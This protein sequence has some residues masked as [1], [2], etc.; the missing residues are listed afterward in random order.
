MTIAWLTSLSILA[1]LGLLGFLMAAAILPGHKWTHYLPVSYLLGSGVFTWALFLLAWAGM[2]INV[3][4]VVWLFALMLLGVLF[5]WT[6]ARR[7]LSDSAHQPA[8]SFDGA[9]SN[10]RIFRGIA[11]M[12][13]LVLWVWA[14][15]VAVGR[16]YWAWDS[17]AIW[18]VRGH[19]IALEGTVFTEWGAHGLSYPLN[20][21]LQI[22]LF[23]L[24]NAEMLPGGKLVFPLYYVSALAGILIFW[25][26]KG[27]PSYITVLGVLLIGTVP[28]VFEQATNGYADLAQAAYLVIG[29]LYAV[30]GIYQ[31]N[32][33]ASIL[34]GMLIGL[35]GWTRLEGT[36]YGVAILAALLVLSS[37]SRITLRRIATSALWFGLIVGPWLAFYRQYGAEG[38]TSMNA[39]LEF[40]DD[41]RMGQVDLYPLRLILGFLRRQMFDPAI[42]GLLFPAC[43]VLGLL[44]WR[45]F[46]QRSE[47]VVLTIVL[48]GISIGAVTILLYFG[49][50]FVA[51]DFLAW[52]RQSF[53]RAFLPS[54]LCAWIVAVLVTGRGQAENKWTVQPRSG[55]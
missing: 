12:V 14:S 34:A 55:V 33:S 45:R 18:G 1:L 52:M 24:G 20:L 9:N 49:I 54:A 4:T 6:R 32:R 19:G 8:A 38:S 7:A 2:P 39:W 13:L 53:A 50:S 28:Q 48:V 5:L 44:S 25:L 35:G 51:P 37:L 3:P 27:V 47:P 46:V 10:N 36:L 23:E 43:I 15:W 17:A 16:S 41:I 21:P 42:W 26:Q 31:D 30:E 11:M 40:L 22:T 29:A